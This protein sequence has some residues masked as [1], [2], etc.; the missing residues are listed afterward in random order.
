MTITSERRGP[1]TLPARRA[2]PDEGRSRPRRAHP[3]RAAL[4]PVRSG[5]ATWR[6]S[7]APQ[8]RPRQHGRSRPEV[9][10]S[11]GRSGAGTHRPS[12]QADRGGR[13]LSRRAREVGEMS[14]VI[15]VDE[16]EPGRH[17]RGGRAPAS[18][19]RS[20]PPT[21]SRSSTPTEAHGRRRSAAAGRLPFASHAC[22]LH[23][24][25]AARH[26]QERPRAAAGRRGPPPGAGEPRRRPPS[27]ARSA[28][29]R[30]PRRRDPRGP[31]AG[32]RG[33]R[34]GRSRPSPTRSARTRS[35]SGRTA[36]AASGRALMGSVAEA[37]I[38]SS[39]VPVLV[40]RDGMRVAAG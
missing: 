27:P 2:Q 32:R 6:R 11:A 15:A 35:R 23:W 19:G 13:D 39:S 9:P 18:A 12:R 37:L 4:V 22:R 26:L 30:P 38:R 1:P 34:T 25:P 7:R 20:P 31:R 28:G 24:R 40:V 3:A 10:P 8:A 36:A 16:S 5:A 17:R 33:R 21:C 14:I 29:R